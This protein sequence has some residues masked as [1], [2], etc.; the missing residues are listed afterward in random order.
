MI[1]PIIFAG[2]SRA[3][4]VRPAIFLPEYYKRIFISSNK[5]KQKTGANGEFFSE[6]R[7]YLL[8]TIRRRRFFRGFAT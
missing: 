5:R 7:K 1:P 2:D 3:F 4:A 8:K 6:T